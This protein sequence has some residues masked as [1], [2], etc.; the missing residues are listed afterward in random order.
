[1]QTFKLEQLQDVTPKSEDGQ[2]PVPGQQTQQGSGQATVPCRVQ[3]F[4]VKERLCKPPE[5][6]ELRGAVERGPE[7]RRAPENPGKMPSDVE[8][9]REQGHS[10][11]SC[12]PCA[13]SGWKR[14]RAVSE[15]GAWEPLWMGPPR[16]PAFLLLKGPR[17]LW[18]I[19][20]ILT[21]VLYPTF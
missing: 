17:A 9:D 5:T 1:M 6:S 15:R 21:F 2:P 16:C 14:G 12:A 3:S 18:P 7:M 11:S 10:C 8:A 20:V 13:P 19:V 4:W